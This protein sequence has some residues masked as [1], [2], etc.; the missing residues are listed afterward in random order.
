MTNTLSLAV[1]AD[2]INGMWVEM[3]YQNEFLLLPGKATYNCYGLIE[4]NFS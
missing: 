3:A 1:C 2:L 4:K